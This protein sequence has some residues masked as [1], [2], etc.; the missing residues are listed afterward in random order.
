MKSYNY[1][2]L[3]TFQT[4]ITADHFALIDD[5]EVYTE[6]EFSVTANSN[7]SEFWGDAATV[8]VRTNA[9]GKCSY[10]DGSND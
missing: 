4:F 5:L 1:T 9:T 7:E 6:Y 10:T 8:D 3:F 2:I